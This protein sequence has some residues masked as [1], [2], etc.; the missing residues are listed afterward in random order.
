MPPNAAMYWSCL[1]TVRPSRSI[2]ISQASRPRSAAETWLRCMACTALSSP[3]VNEPDEPRPVPEGMSAV[4][5]D[6]DAGADVVGAQHLADDR[7]LDLV[8]LVD[9]LELAVLEEVVVGERAVDRDVDVLGDR[10][11][12]DHAAVLLVVR[13]QVGAAAAEGDPQRR[14]GDQHAAHPHRAART[15]ATAAICQPSRASSRLSGKPLPKNAVTASPGRTARA[16]RGA[17]APRDQ[18]LAAG[19]HGELVEVEEREA[20]AQHP[21]DV[22]AGVGE[23]LVRAS[24]R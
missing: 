2:S 13:R 24:G 16:G 8:G 5:D 4:R 12:D 23:H 22:E 9:P 17:P 14:A 6:L 15:C 3:T 11:G 21:V 10:G 7:V 19:D 20:G 1:P 18:L